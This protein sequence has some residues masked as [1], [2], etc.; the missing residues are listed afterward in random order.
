MN[1]TDGDVELYIGNQI[2]PKIICPKNALLAFDSVS[3][4]GQAYVRNST[5]AGGSVYIHFWR[6]P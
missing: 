2:D 4:E 5:G 6:S 3:Y 1:L